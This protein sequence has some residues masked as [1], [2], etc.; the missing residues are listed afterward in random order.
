[1][2]ARKLVMLA[3][4][5]GLAAVW[6]CGDADGNRLDCS[7]CPNDSTTTGCSTAYSGCDELPLRSVRRACFDTVTTQ[8]ANAGCN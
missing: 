2:I 6:G 3:L 4:L 5:G 1:M 7:T 8:F